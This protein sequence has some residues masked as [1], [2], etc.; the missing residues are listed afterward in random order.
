[1]V[2]RYSIQELRAIRVEMFI[3][4]YSTSYSTLTSS[5]ADFF[6]KA[7]QN[8]YAQASIDPTKVRRLSEIEAELLTGDGR[9]N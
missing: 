8:F 5:V 1:M 3:T 9:V 6:K 4:D 2:I 7:Q